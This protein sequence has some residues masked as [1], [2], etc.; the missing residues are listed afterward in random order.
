MY[1]CVCVCLCVERVCVCVG[2]CARAFVFTPQQF[3]FAILFFFNL[4]LHSNKTLFYICCAS[5]LR[6]TARFRCNSLCTNGHNG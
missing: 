2:L 1:L 5:P 4:Y 6:F 3:H